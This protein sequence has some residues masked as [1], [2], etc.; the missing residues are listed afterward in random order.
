MGIV[1]HRNPLIDSHQALLQLVLQVREMVPNGRGEAG[2]AGLGEELDFVVLPA[3]LR[4]E[5]I[6]ETAKTD[7]VAA[8]DIASF[9]AMAEEPIDQELIAI[10]E[11]GLGPVN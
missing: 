6:L 3:I 4:D 9:E 2:Q 1:S 10:G 11:E 5:V 7:T 8:E